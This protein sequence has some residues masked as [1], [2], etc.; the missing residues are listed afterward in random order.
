MRKFYFA[1]LS[2]I[3]VGC[4]STNSVTQ[5]K[6]VQRF[7]TQ[8]VY[9]DKKKQ[10]TQQINL[11]V[12]ARRNLNLRLDAK[13][14]LG[15]HIASVVMNPD[16]IQVA[17]HAERKSY[18]GPAS[19]KVLQ[20]ALGLP[21]HPLVFHAMLYRQAM[22]GAGWQCEAANG[23]VMSCKQESAGLTVSWEDLED[24]E[25]MVTADSK[26]FQL[27]WK[28]PTPDNVEERPSYFVLK[29]PDSYDKLSL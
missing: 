21:L 28:I 20:R 1:F 22:K 2:F 27:Q 25:T 4:A 12:V 5:Q 8:A 15:V 9:L 18:D 26:N 17:L 6:T 16:R 13:V 14:I 29:I 10:K 19:Q 24:S 23:K 3:L 11:E 7:N